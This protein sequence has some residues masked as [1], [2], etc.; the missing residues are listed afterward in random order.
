MMRNSVILFF[1][2]NFSKPVLFLGLT[3]C[4]LAAPV[5]FVNSGVRVPD[6]GS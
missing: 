4:P 3:N 2:L 6:N 5:E 1:N